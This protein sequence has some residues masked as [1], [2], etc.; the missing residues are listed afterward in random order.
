MSHDL[1]LTKAEQVEV[2]VTLLMTI[3]SPDVV[4]R[5]EFACPLLESRP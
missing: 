2:P 3:A 5:S 1:N 4:E